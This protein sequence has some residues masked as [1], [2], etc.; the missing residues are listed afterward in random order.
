MSYQKNMIKPMTAIGRVIQLD[1]QGSNP[2]HRDGVV[3]F[4]QVASSYYIT[5]RLKSLP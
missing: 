4:L 5:P 2:L 3:D 1:C